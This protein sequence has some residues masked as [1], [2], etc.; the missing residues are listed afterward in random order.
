MCFGFTQG[1]ILGGLCSPTLLEEV[2]EHPL[3]LGS[4]EKFKVDMAGARDYI[5]GRLAQYFLSSL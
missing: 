1:L 4:Q 5:K 3:G 2:L